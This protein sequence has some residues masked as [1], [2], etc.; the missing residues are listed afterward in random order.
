[1]LTGL[2]LVFILLAAVL[3]AAESAFTYLPRQEA[4]QLLSSGRGR[5]LATI[6]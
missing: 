4:E 1:M 3:T 6:L 2:A 5:R